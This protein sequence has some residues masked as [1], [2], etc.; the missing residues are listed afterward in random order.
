MS[1]LASNL[2]IPDAPRRLFGFDVIDLIGEGA[3]S[4][5]YKVRDA[6]SGSSR[7]LKLVTRQSD[8]DMRFVEQLQ[9]EHDVSRR[10][11][12]ANLRRCFSVHYERTLL[13]KIISA[14]LLMEWF[15]GMPLDRRLPTELPELIDTFIA[16]AE[17]LDAMHQAGLVHC[18]LKPA[19]ILRNH[20]GEVKV[21]DLGQACPIGTK[22]ERIQGTPDYIAPEQVKRQPVD[23]RTDVYNFGATMYWCLAGQGMPTLFTVERKDNSFLVDQFIKSP[24]DH[25]PQVPEALSAFVMECA[26][27]NPLRRPESMSIVA[28]RLSIIRHAI[29]R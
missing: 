14:G 13:R 16:V 20:A 2:A 5:I 3:G 1:V 10:V 27:T 22:K 29:V 28:R 6:A 21:I 17:G 23:A 18:D 8:R 24:R 15:D 26:R 4:R 25:N 11:G 7:A 12:H 19:N 9:N